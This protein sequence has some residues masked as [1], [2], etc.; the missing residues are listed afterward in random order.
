MSP[1]IRGLM[2]T[3]WHS[4]LGQRTSEPTAADCGG[5]VMEFQVDSRIQKLGRWGIEPMSE[6]GISKGH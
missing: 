4:D 5:G 3:V 2:G 6:G 1:R